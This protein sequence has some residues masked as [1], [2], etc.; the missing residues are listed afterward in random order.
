MNTQTLVEVFFITFQIYYL[1]IIFFIY[2]KLFYI[3]IPIEIFRLNSSNFILFL[4]LIFSHPQLTLWQAN[5]SPT[6]LFLLVLL[7][8]GV[9][10]QNNLNLKTLNISYLYFSIYLI[11][12]I[13][14][15]NI[16]I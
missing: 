14:I 9:I 2:S 8:K 12:N 13:M 15:R 1:R 10:N 6:I 11:S 16:L 4:C 5:F 3:F 7:F